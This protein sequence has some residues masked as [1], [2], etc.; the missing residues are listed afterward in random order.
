[1]TDSCSTQT[2]EDELAIAHRALSEG[3]LGHAAFHIATALVTDPSNAEAVAVFDGWF[4]TC[5]N[6]LALVTGQRNESWEG[7]FAMRARTYAKLGKAEDALFLLA[8]LAAAAPD[9]G[10][11]TWLSLIKAPGQLSDQ[12]VERAAT[13]LLG[14]ASSLPEPV[15]V[16]DPARPTIT[17]ALGLLAGW[18]ETKRHLAVPLHAIAIFQRKLGRIEEALAAA[19]ALFELRPDW[20]SVGTLCSTLRANGDLEGALDIA[21]RGTALAPTDSRAAM[22]L[23]V[24]DL[25]LDLERVAEARQAYGAALELEPDNAWASSGFPY[26]RYRELGNE[27]DRAALRQW[28]LE[29]PDDARAFQLLSHIGQPLLEKP[30]VPTD[31][32]ANV[33]RHL[34]K[35]FLENPPET[36]PAK[37]SLGLSAPEAPSNMLAVGLLERAFGQSLEIDV[38]VAEVSGPDP[39][40]PLAGAEVALWRRVGDDF[41]PAFSAPDATVQ[42]EVATIAATPY[43]L[44]AWAERARIL[45]EALGP[46]RVSDLLATMVHP[47]ALPNAAYDTARWIQNVQVAAALAIGYVD[48]GWEGS[49]RRATLLSLARGPVD[50]SVTAATVALM[51]LGRSEP[52]SVSEIEAVF[53]QLRQRQSYNDEPLRQAWL[54][55]PGVSPEMRASLQG[56]L[57]ALLGDESEDE[58]ADEDDADDTAAAPVLT[59]SARR[60]RGIAFVVALASL[61]FAVLWPHAWGEWWLLIL[62]VG[63]GVA[64]WFWISGVPP[65]ERGTD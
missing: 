9:K 56:E 13:Q 28:S 57:D 2:I 62:V 27:A 19:H 60:H 15:A 3:D 50:W 48:R 59:P 43:R 6:A 47:P 38:S 63:W 54:L 65:L 34:Q 45:G 36:A 53:G 24:G 10:Y 25:C 31:A 40:E 21:R 29:H 30:F 35:S 49:T 55:L 32:T 14:L 11:L 8:K 4:A 12:G 22:W 37:A 18:R 23:D 16:N 1:M 64:F 51:W 5:D 39:R 58:D 33:F 61:F 7:W 26:A 42:R 41:E 17:L 52:R 20:R 44:S 46:A